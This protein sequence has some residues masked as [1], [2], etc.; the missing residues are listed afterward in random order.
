MSRLDGRI[1]I[2]TGATSGIGRAI[3][4]RLAAEGAY[5]VATGRNE[6]QGAVT[7][8][9]I[10]KTGR[11]WFR[12]QDVT[13]PDG[14]GSLVDEVERGLGGLDV[15]VNNAGLFF[16]KPLEDTTE[17]DFD[18]IYRVNVEGTFLGMQ[19]AAAAMARRGG[20]S[21]VNI[22]SLLGVRGFP[23][24]SAYCATKGAVT[25]MTLSA[26]VELGRS[27]CP[28]RVNVIHPGVYWT[29]AVAAQMGAD[30]SVR[31]ALADATPLGRL[32]EP[33]EVAGAVAYLASDEARLVTGS[34]MTIDGGRGAR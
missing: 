13:D 18:A 20:G 33:E 26:A 5:V 32:G 25:Q 1:A 30:R 8:A 28:I 21:I 3:A 24:A 6:D 19:A 17:E 12:H 16:V 10:E 4:L 29:E 31:Q 11:G 23:G 27:G 22:S 34:E 15:L 7:L 2:V 9:A 14:W